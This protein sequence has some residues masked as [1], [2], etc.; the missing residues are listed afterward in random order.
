MELGPVV[1]PIQSGDDPFQ[2]LMVCTANICRSPGA[3]RLLA[4]ELSRRDL[5][6]DLY[7]KISSAGVR[8]WIAQP[9]DPAAAEALE[10][11]GGTARGFKSRP[12]TQQ[13]V[14][15]ASLILTATREHRSEVVETYPRALR[16]T[17]TMKEFAHLASLPGTAD[18]VD[19]QGQLSATDLVA[20]AYRHRGGRR[21]T[22]LDVADPYGGTTAQHDRAMGEIH[23]CVRQIAVAL[24]TCTHP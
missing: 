14:D 21:L 22:D 23:A 8:G 7:L 1:E 12:L 6:E 20:S 17:F 3:E 15:S 19:A 5:S 18:A 11:R 9:M 13:I 24:A 2:I 10:R 16:R 4:L